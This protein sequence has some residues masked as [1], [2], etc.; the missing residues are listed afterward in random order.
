MDDI[1]EA[2][3]GNAEL[4]GIMRSAS[5][6]QPLSQSTSSAAGG[7]IR[8]RDQPASRNGADVTKRDTLVA[9]DSDDDSS[10]VTQRKQLPK[11]P[12]PP[13]SMKPA[14]DFGRRAPEVKAPAAPV[15]EVAKKVVFATSTQNGKFDSTSS[16][17][18]AVNNGRDVAP[19]VKQ[20]VV[21]SSQQ[22]QREE[23]DSSRRNTL[24][25]SDEDE[26]D[27]SDAE[28]DK[29]DDTVN[30]RLLN[31]SELLSFS[32]FPNASDISDINKTRSLKP[33]VNKVRSVLQIIFKS[34]F[35]D[36]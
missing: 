29:S 33:A 17:R 1:M 21:T 25:A 12:A 10:H 24:V 2:L 16:T 13:I 32:R 28:S 36:N 6:Q 15:S 5:S 9:E 3:E 26:D 19:A 20:S 35:C 22:Q 7:G 27:D 31:L 11:A 14:N 34:V 4:S 18:A 30:E 23:E 8:L